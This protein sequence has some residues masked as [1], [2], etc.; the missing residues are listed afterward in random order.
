MTIK[1]IFIFL[2]LCFCTSIHAQTTFLDAPQIKSIK[3]H[4]TNNSDS[5][6]IFNMSQSFLF[7]FDKVDDEQQ[8]YSYKILHC[9]LDWNISNLLTSNYIDGFDEFNINDFEGSF[10]TLNFYTHYQFQIPNENTAITRTGNY[11]IQIKND[12]DELVCERKIILYRQKAG[13][14]LAV[15]EDQDVRFYNKKQFV[16]LKVNIDGL[17]V[18]APQQE[19]KTLVFQNRDLNI[20]T[21]WLQPTHVINNVLDYRNPKKSTF[22][23]SNEFL[24]FDNYELLRRSNTVYEA[25]REDNFFNTILYG[26]SPRTNKRYKYNPDVNGDFVVRKLNTENTDTEADYSYTYF[27]LANSEKFKDQNIYVYGAFNNFQLSD[28]N[29]L[30]YDELKKQHKGILLL[31]QGFYNY[32]YAIKKPNGSVD[33]HSINGTHFYTENDYNALVYL[34]PRNDFFYEVIGYAKANA[35]NILEN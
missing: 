10:G 35:K 2:F 19:I 28:E 11:I 18:N 7:E 26:T 23:G 6:F 5:Q 15:S 8:N 33:L 13:I 4:A 25:Y 27:T 12:D 17:G 14:S 3:I 34:Q 20:K 22:Y 29:L 32:M 31:K 21:D 30:T 16:S 9:D 24:Y 1:Q